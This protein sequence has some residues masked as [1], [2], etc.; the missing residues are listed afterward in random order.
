MAEVRKR[1]GDDETVAE[2]VRRK[3]LEWLGH[4]AR[5][6]DHRVPKSMLFSW[7]C[8]PCPMQMWS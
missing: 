4:L 1:W 2:K 6:P 8:E 5:L 7:L 3:S